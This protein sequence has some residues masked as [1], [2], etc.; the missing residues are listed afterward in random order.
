MLPTSGFK[1]MLYP[2]S[3]DIFYSE[4]K[5]DALGVIQKSWVFDR[6]IKCSIISQMSGGAKTIAGEI[7]SN[8][9]TFSYNSE[10]LIR[11]GQDVQE[12]KNGTIYPITE[13][14]ITNIKDSAGKLAWREK[15]SIPTQYELKT[16]IISF[17]P[18]H[19][20]EFYRG[21]LSRSTKQNEV[22]Y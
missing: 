13:I 5:Q 11:T 12:K 1:D 10:L 9:S 4:N 15:G 16:F 6:T 3:A 7:K 21:F 14:L 17:N 20:I 19:E 2:M 8:S 18:S 22:L